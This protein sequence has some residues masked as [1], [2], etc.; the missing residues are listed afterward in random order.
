MKG[1]N[2][3]ASACDIVIASNRLPFTLSLDDGALRGEP[4][5]GG[6]VTALQGAREP[7]DLGRLARNARS[8]PSSRR[9]PRPSRRTPAACRS[10]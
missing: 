10:S 9:R 4:S 7:H 1:E 2:T 3:P 8:R 6:L 5:S